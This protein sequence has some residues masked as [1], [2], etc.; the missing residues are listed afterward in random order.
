MDAKMTQMEMIRRHL[1]EGKSIDPMEALKEYGCYRLGAII[2][3][4]RKE[5]YCI[6]TRLQYHKN[7]YGYTSHYA[8]YKLVNEGE[9]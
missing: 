9:M 3:M 8:I 7:K 6:S 5:G 2:H 1:H 4:L